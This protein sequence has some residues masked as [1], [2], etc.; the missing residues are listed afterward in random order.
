MNYTICRIFIPLDFIRLAANVQKSKDI[1]KSRQYYSLEKLTLVT[2]YVSIPMHLLTWEVT[3]IIICN[4]NITIDIEN[5]ISEI[6]A[7]PST[8]ILMKSF[9]YAISIA[10]LDPISEYRGSGFAFQSAHLSH[11]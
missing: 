5:T 7:L 8:K 3:T 9:P 1:D 4:I 6:R 11:F 2:N 10:S